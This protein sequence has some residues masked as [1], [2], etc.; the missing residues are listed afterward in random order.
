M[1]LIF[2]NTWWKT[3]FFS[4]ALVTFRPFPDILKTIMTSDT[5]NLTEHL[6]TCLC[7]SKKTMTLF[8]MS[9]FGRSCHMTFYS[10]WSEIKATFGCCRQESHIVQQHSNPHTIL[11]ISTTKT[12]LLTVKRLQQRISVHWHFKDTFSAF[13]CFVILLWVKLNQMLHKIIFNQT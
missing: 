13:A 11:L 8:H 7:S 10:S 5:R 3:Y 6:Q 9:C 2:L 4:V 1:S 12:C